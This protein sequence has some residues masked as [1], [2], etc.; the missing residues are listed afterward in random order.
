[1][2]EASK[3]LSLPQDRTHFARSLRGK[4]NRDRGL[5]F[6]P[7]TTISGG[8][9]TSLDDSLLH[10]RANSAIPSPDVSANVR[11]STRTK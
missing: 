5:S 8:A 11:R 7:L 1:V 3:D 9:G 4:T 2:N 10:V 6:N